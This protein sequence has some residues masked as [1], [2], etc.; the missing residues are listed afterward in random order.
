MTLGATEARSG[1]KEATAGLA[2]E[3]WLASYRRGLCGVPALRRSAPC[4]PA[5]PSARLK[6][7]LQTAGAAAARFDRLGVVV[8]HATGPR[9]RPRRDSMASGFS[10]GRSDVSAMMVYPPGAPC[11]VRSWFA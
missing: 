6:A 5:P 4:W 7:G 11:T 9:D 10:S 3:P 1:V 8:Y 2:P